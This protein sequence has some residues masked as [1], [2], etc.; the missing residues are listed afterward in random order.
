MAG[1]RLTL[2]ERRGLWEHHAPAVPDAGRSRGLLGGREVN[3]PADN[4]VTLSW[5][6]KSGITKVNNGAAIPWCRLLMA[7]VAPRT[8]A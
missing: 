8:L 7:V 1:R 6:N 5:A 2:R 4:P 3:G